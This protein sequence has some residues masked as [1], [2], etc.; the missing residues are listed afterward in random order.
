M[1]SLYLLQNLQKSNI[2]LSGYFLILCLESLYEGSTIVDS[3]LEFL[4]QFLIR[5]WGFS[6]VLRVHCRF[7]SSYGPCALLSLS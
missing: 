6:S 5:T 7:Y 1:F 3:L 2:L 4:N